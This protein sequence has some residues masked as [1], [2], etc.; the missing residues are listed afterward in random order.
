[1]PESLLPILPL[2]L[3]TFHGHNPELTGDAA[4]EVSI[5]TLAL[6]GVETEVGR[7]P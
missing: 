2:I 7:L 1:M 6:V 4:A 3:L 5:G